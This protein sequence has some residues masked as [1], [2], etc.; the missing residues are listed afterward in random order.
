MAIYANFRVNGTVHELELTT[1]LQHRLRSFAI[2]IG[3]T[4]TDALSMI[5]A[6]KGEVSCRAVQ[7]FMDENGVHE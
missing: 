1:I 5:C 6:Q 2:S 4:E 7:E 3:K